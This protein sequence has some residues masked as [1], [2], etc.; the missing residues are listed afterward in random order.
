MYGWIITATHRAITRA[1]SLI[2]LFLMLTIAACNDNT[3][4]VASILPSSTPILEG[5]F[6]S[7]PNY[8]HPSTITSNEEMHSST[9]IKT[10]LPATTTPE[11]TGTIQAATEEIVEQFVP[12]LGGADKI[13]FASNRDGN[14]EIYLMKINVMV[15]LT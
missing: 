15:R 5:I 12:E 6:T 11:P 3:L 9:A 13:A 14:Y 1:I 8:L 7:E 4:D 10:T 2:A